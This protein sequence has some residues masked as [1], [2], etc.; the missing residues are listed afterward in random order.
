MENTTVTRD[1]IYWFPDGNIVLLTHDCVAFRVHQSVLS[2]HSEFFAGMFEDPLPIPEDAVD[3][4]ETLDGCRIVPLGDTAYDIRHLV[5][6]MYGKGYV[7]LTN[8]SPLLIAY[9]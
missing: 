5:T 7:F 9:D 6:I 4:D 8:T 3:K 2:L 1:S